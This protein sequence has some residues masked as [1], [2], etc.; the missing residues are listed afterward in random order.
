MYIH[1]H[2][3]IIEQYI[4]VNITV[5]TSHNY[6]YLFANHIANVFFSSHTMKYYRI[7]SYFYQSKYLLRIV[8]N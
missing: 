2:I 8:N 1:I 4:I 6:I 5:P 7:I 3:Y